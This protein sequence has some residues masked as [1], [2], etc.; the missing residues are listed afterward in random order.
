MEPLKEVLRLWDPMQGPQVLERR[1]LPMQP[2]LDRDIGVVLSWKLLAPPAKGPP[3]S[4]LRGTQHN[5]APA[6]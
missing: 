6:R 5:G 3:S 1:G 2:P 4:G